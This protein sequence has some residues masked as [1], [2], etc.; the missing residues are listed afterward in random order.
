MT[1]GP[2]SQVRSLQSAHITF[3]GSSMAKRKTT[4]A[5]NDERCTR[6]ILCVLSCSLFNYGV[7][8]PRKS[9]IRLNRND[10]ITQFGLSIDNGCKFCGE[11]KRAFTHSDVIIVSK[12][13][14]AVTEYSYVHGWV[15]KG[16]FPPEKQ[17]RFG[18]KQWMKQ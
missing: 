2:P 16:N 1:Q 15:N 3:K 9:F 11:R 14:S 6:C 5:R 8:N 18:I 13:S 7:F 12:V 10:H 4:I 17:E